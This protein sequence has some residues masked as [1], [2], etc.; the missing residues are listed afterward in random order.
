M[1]GKSPDQRQ[2]SFVNGELTTLL[3]P[4]NNLYALANKIPWNLLEQEFEEFYSKVGQPAKPIRLM[5]GLL[6]LRQMF[7]L[8]DEGVIETWKM[9]PYFQYFCGEIE[10]QWN[11]PCDSSDLTYFRKRIGEKGAE[12]I[13]QIS[14]HLHTDVFSE[15]TIILDTT[16][17]EKNITFPTDQKQHLKIIEKCRRIAKDE[18]ISLRQTFKK[19][20]KNLLYKLRFEKRKLKNKEIK[21]Y[22][23]R[24]KTIAIKL[25][26][27]IS[28]KLPE[29]QLEKYSKDVLIYMKVLEQKKES[30][31]KIYSLHEP[32]VQCIAKGKDHKKYEFGTKTSFA[33][34]P[35]SGVIVGALAFENNPYDGHTLA[36]ALNQTTKLIGQRPKLGIVDRGYKGINQLKGTTILYPNQKKINDSKE[37]AKIKSHLRQ[38]SAIEP[39]IGHLKSDF[40]LQRNYLK[41]FIGDSINA[42]LAAAAFNFKYA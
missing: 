2:T 14:I 18:N 15:E 40:R 33:Y 4:K 13:F 25:L 26:R 34:A 17:Q 9:N 23:K 30:K 19:E 28:R 36:K 35:N 1:K 7:N 3:N 20:I 16:V 32:H 24:I 37:L 11:A 29:R 22:R 12:K 38:R 21:K 5:S 6:I 10:F 42:L 39:I 41:G 27:E 31:N 8:S